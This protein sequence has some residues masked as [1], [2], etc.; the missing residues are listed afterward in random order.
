METS[1]EPIVDEAEK[2]SP[3]YAKGVEEETKGFARETLKSKIE[4]KV[5]DLLT[6]V[7]KK[8]GQ[9]FVMS[10]MRQE[11]AAQADLG[12]RVQSGL[13]EGSYIDSNGVHEGTPRSYARE[14]F[15]D[16]NIGRRNLNSGFEKAT[17]VPGGENLPRNVYGLDAKAEKPYVEFSA[18]SRTGREHFSITN[19]TGVMRA[20][21]EVEANPVIKTLE[22]W[23]GDLANK[24]QAIDGAKQMISAYSAVSVAA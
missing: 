15:S 1:V 9:S 5:Y 21:N 13:F 19:S 4:G 14:I 23:R 20:Q 3:D 12:R 8:I 17:F 11:L 10:Q 24:R 2:I 7:E 16:V 6:S 18:N 22:K